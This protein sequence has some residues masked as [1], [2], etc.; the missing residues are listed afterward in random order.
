[1]STLSNYSHL[2][3][4]VKKIPAN[5]KTMNPE[6]THLPAEVR[7]F[8][9]LAEAQLMHLVPASVARLSLFTLE[10]ALG[11]VTPESEGYS[12]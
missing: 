4:F 8:S 5:V 3:S 12:V 1:M 7:F 11:A 9:R 6:L 2:D 10:T